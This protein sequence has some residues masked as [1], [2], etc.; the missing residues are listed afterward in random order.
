VRVGC[1]VVDELA[2]GGV[3]GG[4]GEDGLNLSVSGEGAGGVGGD[5]GAR[6]IELEGALLEASEDLGYVVSVPE[7]E[8][9]GVDED[10]SAGIFCFDL[11]A[12]EDGLGEGLADGE[13]F[14]CVGGG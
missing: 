3:V 13:L 1:D 7:V 5:G 9:G 2:L 12:E 8:V 4:E 10:G 14:C 6:G 11:E